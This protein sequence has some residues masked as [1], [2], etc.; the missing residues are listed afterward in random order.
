MDYD[1]LAR[2]RRNIAPSRRKDDVMLASIDCLEVLLALYL[3]RA[4]PRACGV[5]NTTL[6]PY[7]ASL[8]PGEDRIAVAGRRKRQFADDHCDRAS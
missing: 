8:S 4:G 2:L 1:K 5:T 3:Q 6:R 7:G